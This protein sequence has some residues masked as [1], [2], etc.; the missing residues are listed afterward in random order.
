[1]TAGIAQAQAAEVYYNPANAASSSGQ[2][3]GY[4]LYKTIGCP[5]RGILDAP[6]AG[7]APAKPAAPAPVAKIADTDGDGISDDKDRCPGTPSG[8][9]VDAQGCELDGD[10]DGVV[11][12]LDKCPTTPAGRKVNAEG[13][14]LDGDNDG[15]VDAL[16]KCPTTP[17][18]RAVNAEGCELDGDNDGVVDALDK[19][20]T[21]P[22]GNKVNSQ[23]CD[24]DTDGDGIVDQAD[25]CPTTPAGD[26]VDAKG[27]SLPKVINLE[28]VN[29]DTNK[30]T[31]RPE[32]SAIL[33]DAAATLKRYPGLKVE[34]AG[35]TDSASGD[36]HNLDLSQRRANAVMKYFVDKG[37]E[38]DRLTAKGYGESLPVADNATSAGRAKNRRVELRSLN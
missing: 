10:K 33:D 37:I 1:M 20:P 5:G 9:K 31:L 16:D 32:S 12:R 30:D 35:H 8:A 13:C 3:T 14:E 17:A 15:I 23:G 18:G 38:A 28:G 7:P 4:D 26:R 19:C 36:A 25:Q 24:L 27:C 34:I 21:T 29:F 22:A 6:C 2:T 11:D